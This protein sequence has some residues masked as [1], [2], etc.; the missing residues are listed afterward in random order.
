[1]SARPP[2]RAIL[3]LAAL[4]TAD[5]RGAVAQLTPVG[6]EFQINA[7]IT[8]DNQRSADV[9]IAGDGSFVVAWDSNESGYKVRAQRFARNGQ[10]LGDEILIAPATAIDFYVP[11]LA[12]EADGDF[13]VVW[14]SSGYD[15]FGRFFERSGAPRGDEFPISDDSYWSNDVAM[16]SEGSFVV[17]W[18]GYYGRLALR[19][20]RGDGQPAGDE[21][22]VRPDP[23]GGRGF[24]TDVAMDGRGGHVLVWQESHPTTGSDE[25]FAQLFDSAGNRIGGELQVNTY[26]PLH[27]DSPVV[28]MRRD[29]SFVVVWRSTAQGRGGLFAQ[30]FDGD[31]SRIGGEIQV[32]PTGE[33]GL[34]EPAVAVGAGSDF[35]VA[36][37]TGSPGAAERDVFAQH[38]IGDRH[39]GAEIRVNT[40]VAGAQFR[41]AVAVG[42]RGET[43]VVWNSEGQDGSRHGIYGQRLSGIASSDV[44][45]DG[46]PDSVDNCPTVANPDQLDAD[47]DGF[48]DDCVPPDVVLPPTARFG[49]NPV[50]GRGTRIE[51]GVVFGDDATIGELVR[52]FREARGGT[53]SASATWSRSA[54]V[55]AWATT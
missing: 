50:I 42:P 43:V 48:G 19:R 16:S 4:E 38:V 2:L 45:G 7:A 41:P 10:H 47:G 12:V 52:L 34:S 28:A 25:I 22:E 26:T 40:H 33:R 21:L 11:R 20:F 37:A 49:S 14:Q 36:W 23:N 27:Q 51:A 44:D 35:V 18:Q 8:F 54:V 24:G 32:A 13:L 1:M 6:G 46:V 53:A 17:A 29:G 9:G 30:R 15:S 39:G 55:P 5:A 3:F 31:G